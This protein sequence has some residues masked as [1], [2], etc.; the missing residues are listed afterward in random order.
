MTYLCALKVASVSYGALL[1]TLTLALKTLLIFLKA[2][3]LITEKW[4]LALTLHICGC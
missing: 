4:L 1:S 3:Q 2:S